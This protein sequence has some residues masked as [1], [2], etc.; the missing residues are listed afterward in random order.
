MPRYACSLEVAGEGFAGTAPQPGERCVLPVFRAALKR[1][2][3]FAPDSRTCGRLDAG[4]H[5]ADFVIHCDAE[6]AWQP[7]RLGGAL[8]AHLPPDLAVTRVAAV[9][10]DWDARFAVRAK[11]YAYRVLVRSARP[12]LD[13]RRL[14]L[15]RL[16]HPE[17]L[18]ACAALLVGEHDL[19]AFACR[20]GDG[21][22]PERA[23]RRI[24]AATWTA[25]PTVDATPPGADTD[26]TFRITGAGFLY[27]QV[28]GLT[29]AMLAVAADRATVADFAAAIDAG[30]D[31][32]RLGQ[33]VPAHAL[34][35]ERV[36]YVPAPAWETVG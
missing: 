20:R 16:P 33:V 10:P 11:I 29:G 14:H 15:R 2:G 28:R 17:R 8:N 30:W 35:L 5:A 32:P 19:A 7:A 36:R 13:R 12:A 9:A 3:G 26:W 27:K 23:V 31:H 34:C 22:D 4:V 6:R 21:S 24:D 25:G 1:L 18:A